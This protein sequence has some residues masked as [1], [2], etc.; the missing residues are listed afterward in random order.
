MKKTA[1]AKLTQLDQAKIKFT[2]QLISN[3]NNNSN[4]NNNNKK[5]YHCQQL[6]SSISVCNESYINLPIDGGSLALA[7]SILL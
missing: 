2:R 5:L 7:L 6:V 1:L 4:D 3:F